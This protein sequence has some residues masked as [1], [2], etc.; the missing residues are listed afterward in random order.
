MSHTN[1]DRRDEEAE[2]QQEESDIRACLSLLKKPWSFRPWPAAPEV[3]AMGDGRFWSQE[4]FR[5]LVV[6]LLVQERSIMAPEQFEMAKPGATSFD[7]AFSYKTRSVHN[8]GESEIAA[9]CTKVHA[10]NATFSSTFALAAL[11]R[12][13]KTLRDCIPPAVCRLPTTENISQYCQASLG[14]ESDQFARWVIHDGAWPK[15]DFA[16]H[17]EDLLVCAGATATLQYWW[18]EGYKYV[19]RFKNVHW[20]VRTADYRGRHDARGKL[21]AQKDQFAQSSSSD[22][23][24]TLRW[25]LEYLTHG[26]VN[27]G[28]VANNA[29]HWLA[30]F[31]TAAVIA[32]SLPILQ[33][34][35]T[36]TDPRLWC[37]VVGGG[38]IHTCGHVEWLDHMQ[39][40]CL[41]PSPTVH[42]HS[43]NLVG[44]MFDFLG[45][46][47]RDGTPGYGNRCSCGVAPAGFA[48]AAFETIQYGIERHYGYNLF[49]DSP[50]EKWTQDSKSAIGILLMPHKPDT[51]VTWQ[52][53]RD[54]LKEIRIRTTKRIG[55][56][57]R[58]SGG[59]GANDAD[60]VNR[61]FVRFVETARDTVEPKHTAGALLRP[62]AS[63]YGRSPWAER[64]T[65][66]SCQDCSF[67]TV[68]CALLSLP[69]AMKWPIFH[70]DARAGDIE[71]DMEA[72]ACVHFLLDQQ[73]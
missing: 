13:C 61:E 66:T 6:P 54:H 38:A 7:S 49:A 34:L 33:W 22:C 20:A 60:A 44:S 10:A 69:R 31:I 16:D 42:Y 2:R 18:D 63:R 27:K 35:K 48:S 62:L 72:D 57:D 25:M 21:L 68:L 17:W 46:T 39:E 53:L 23:F 67:V 40:C 9:I 59:R 11:R 41:A 70:H 64:L 47:L 71:C 55:R 28:S 73:M 3:P 5:E 15:P 50:S 1:M 12:A 45:D 30:C 8:S 24:K 14:L 29:C 52:T 36:C 65:E 56:F 51:P 19:L 58:C 32:Q 43:Y 37:V 26:S 4:I